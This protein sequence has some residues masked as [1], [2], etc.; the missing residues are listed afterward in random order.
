MNLII[1]QINE[2]S[3]KTPKFPDKENHL[4]MNNLVQQKLEFIV[5]KPAS[6]YSPQILAFFLYHFWFVAIASYV[7]Q[8]S[9]NFIAASKLL[10]HILSLC[11]DDN[12]HEQFKR[13]DLN[14]QQ[15]HIV[16]TQS[17]IYIWPMNKKKT[18]RRFIIY[19]MAF[20][21]KLKELNPIRLKKLYVVLW[22]RLRTQTSTCTRFTYKNRINTINS[23]WILLNCAAIIRLES[24]NS[25][26]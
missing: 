25:S 4:G 12:E 15:C 10:F 11:K 14:Q 8:I 9:G 23:T 13:F 21:P 3:W 24:S 2:L 17:A 7:P 6:S 16:S 1:K 5:T 26:P 18:S 22:I 20:N 19:L